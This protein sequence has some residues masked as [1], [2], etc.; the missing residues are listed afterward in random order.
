[1]KISGE[2]VIILRVVEPFSRL[3]ELRTS[4]ISRRLRGLEEHYSVMT[5]FLF[6]A[7]SSKI[8]RLFLFRFSVTFR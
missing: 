2:P 4:L 7:A 8:F 3:L 6:H 1:M 5:P